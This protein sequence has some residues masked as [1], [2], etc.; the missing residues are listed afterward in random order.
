MF[1][2]CISVDH[3]LQF[4][5]LSAIPGFLKTSLTLAQARQTVT[6]GYTAS[7]TT[8]LSNETPPR[9]YSVPFVLLHSAPSAGNTLLF[10]KTQRHDARKTKFLEVKKYHRF[11]LLGSRSTEEVFA[12]FTDT[13]SDSQFVSLSM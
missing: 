9:F 1:L 8:A 4:F 13:A 10:V 5:Q 2:S 6:D 3:S 7:D 12:I 11:V